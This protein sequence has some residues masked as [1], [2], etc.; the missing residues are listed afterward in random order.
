MPTIFLRACIA[1]YGHREF[2][3]R[4][5]AQGIPFAVACRLILNREPRPIE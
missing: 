1:A 3:R 2:A 4:L 5:H